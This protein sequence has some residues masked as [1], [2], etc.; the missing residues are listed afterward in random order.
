MTPVRIVGMGSALG[1]DQ[2]G[3]LASEALET[4]K[5]PT[6]FACGL[7][8][9]DKCITPAFLPSMIAGASFVILIDALDEP[10]GGPALRRLEL[11]GI[12]PDSQHDSCHGFS[13]VVALE[14]ARALA[15][16]PFKTIIYGLSLAESLKRGLNC[17]PRTVVETQL[18]ALCR[19]IEKDILRFIGPCTYPR[20]AKP[21]LPRVYPVPAI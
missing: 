1:A 10:E 4:L 16:Y 19:M 11:E 5:F 13:P 18:P 12:E 21:D 9:V 14:L 15:P 7:V 2:A 8:R 17:D 6:R 3:W 20:L